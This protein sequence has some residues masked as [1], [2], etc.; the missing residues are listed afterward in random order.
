MII[1]SRRINRKR[2]PMCEQNCPVRD[3]KCDG[4]NGLRSFYTGA[5]K[6]TAARQ[7]TLG[8]IN[9][10]AEFVKHLTNLEASEEASIA[11]ALSLPSVCISPHSAI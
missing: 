9:R 5:A 11:E 2:P 4:K 3:G 6:Y 10:T 8:R 1:D 7:N